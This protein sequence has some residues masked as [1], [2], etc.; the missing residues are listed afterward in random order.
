M[1]I[2]INYEVVRITDLHTISS[3]APQGPADYVTEFLVN[4]VFSI[5][6]KINS[7]E[8]LKL[9]IDNFKLSARGFVLGL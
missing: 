5:Q 3:F 2:E 8:F 7:L 9:L 6:L 1:T 4:F